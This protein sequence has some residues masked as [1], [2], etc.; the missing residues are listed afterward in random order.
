M[1]TRKTR[2]TPKQQGDDTPPI[3]KGERVEWKLLE[4]LRPPIRDWLIPGFIPA[5]EVTLFA[6]P[7]GVGKSLMAQHLAT[8]ICNG[9]PHTTAYIGGRLERPRKVL[10]CFCED[11]HDELWR[12]QVVINQHMGIKIAT[13]EGRLELL[14]YKR[15]DVTL[16]APVFGVLKPTPM[17]GELARLVSDFKAEFVIV[18]NSAIVFGGNENDRHEVMQFLAWLASACAPAAVM[19]V[20]HPAKTLGSTYSGSTAWEGGVRNRMFM[21]FKNPGARDDDDEPQGGLS[22]RWLSV[23]KANYSELTCRRFELTKDV[24]LLPDVAIAPPKTLT[25]EDAEVVVVEAVKKLATMDQYGAVGI[26]SPNYLPKLAHRFDCVGPMG[27]RQFADTVD[28]MLKTG[29]LKVGKVGAYGNRTAKK[30]I[31]LP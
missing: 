26:T 30:G 19:L 3:P 13:L 10:G 11:D 4:R 21:S 20:A 15:K 31:R 24:Y 12:R 23:G 5:N 6:G 27:R 14:S 17:M 8:A 18:D 22:E 29:A 16:A 25:A 7:P 9:G 1:S 2:M 28:R